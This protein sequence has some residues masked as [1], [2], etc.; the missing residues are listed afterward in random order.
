MRTI[1]R[2]IV[3]AFIFSKDGKLV[4]GRNVNGGVYAD[5][6]VIPG[7][8]IETG[9]SETDALKREVMEEVGLDIS[10]AEIEKVHNDLK[11]ESEKTLKETGER[12]MVEMNFYSYKITLSKVAAEITLTDGDGFGIARWLEPKDFT[13]D[14]FPEPTIKNLRYMG[15]SLN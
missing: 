9:E 2:D 8:G 13:S 10:D 7:G 12:V 1:H 11:G 15:Y 6:W 5:K 14:I 3:G 4:V